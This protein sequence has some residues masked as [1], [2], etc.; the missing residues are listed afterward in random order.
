MRPPRSLPLSNLS[1]LTSNPYF[2]PPETPERA[3]KPGSVANGHFS[4]AAV[5]RRLDA[6]YPDVEPGRTAPERENPKI[7]P[8]CV[9]LG[10][11]PGGV[12]RAG[13]V[14]RS[15]V[16]SYRTFSPLPVP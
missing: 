10:L 9:L 3:C 1:P 16:R 14:A 11:A 4:G 15:A 12:Y 13:P 7:L 2:P 6:T 8:R 5:T